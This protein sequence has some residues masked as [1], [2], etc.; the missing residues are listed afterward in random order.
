MGVLCL[1][2][3]WASSPLRYIMMGGTASR[4]INFNLLLPGMI[5]GEDHLLLSN[6]DL[7]CSNIAVAW[8]RQCWG[9]RW[10]K[11]LP[12]HRTIHERF[13]VII[14]IFNHL[15][16]IFTGLKGFVPE[17][18]DNH[19]KNPWLERASSIWFNGNGIGVSPAI[20][21]QSLIHF[22]ISYIP[23]KLMANF[24]NFSGS[25][26]PGTLHEW[27]SMFHGDL[28]IFAGC[29]AVPSSAKQCQAV[30]SSAKQCQ[31]VTDCGGGP[32][33]FQGRLWLC[34]L[35]QIFIQLSWMTGDLPF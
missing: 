26:P 34:A 31:G 27:I 8:K 30:P 3:P 14:K 1:G 24:Y 21:R 35:D 12:L 11:P 6:P 17:N 20:F 22:S 23:T 7:V 18:L 25:N 15:L 5:W 4:V 16:A 19:P 9:S 13:D 2:L 32:G 29:Q 10:G 33:A 28:P